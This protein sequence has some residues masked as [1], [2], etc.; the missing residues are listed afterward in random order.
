VKLTHVRLLV[1]DA[2]ACFRFY[3]DVVGLTPTWGTETEGYADFDAGGGSTLAI[4][5]REGQSEVVELRGGGDGAILV[6]GVDDLE[7]ALAGLRQRGAEPGEIVDRP[8]W[9]I[10]FAH[11]RDP[12]G[13]LVEVNSPIAM[14]WD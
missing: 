1:D 7:G 14:E 5:G 2:P 10:R 9:G 6:F 11:F 4:M 12:A 13:N 8:D 3:R